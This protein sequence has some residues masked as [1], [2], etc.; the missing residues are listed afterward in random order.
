MKR[1]GGTGGAGWWPGRREDPGKQPEGSGRGGRAGAA[2]ALRAA[3]REGRSCNERTGLELEK[4]GGGTKGQKVAL[5]LQTHLLVPADAR[6][7]E[8]LQHNYQSGI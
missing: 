8:V 4:W 6:G 7:S 1:T 3:K 5:M 2:Q